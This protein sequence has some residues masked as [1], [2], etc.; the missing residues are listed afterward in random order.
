MKTI[1][2]ADLDHLLLPKVRDQDQDRDRARPHLLN[3]VVVRDRDRNLARDQGVARQGRDPDRALDQGQ[4][5]GVQ[6]AVLH[7]I[8]THTNLY[9]VHLSLEF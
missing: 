7:R 1:N 9:F 6:E 3:A 8:K 4:A 5:R 2:E